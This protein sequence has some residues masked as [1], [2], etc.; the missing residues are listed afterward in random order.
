VFEAIAREILNGEL[1]PG[2]MLPS[3][4]ELAERF[5]ISMLVVRQAIHGLEDLGL[6]RVRQ[7]GP[8]MVLDPNKA[9]DIRLLELRVKLAPLG[10]GLGIYTLELRSLFMMQMLLLAE[11]RINEREIGV[12]TYLIDSLPKEPSLDETRHFRMEFWRQIATAT[13]NELVEQQMLWWRAR[14]R[15]APT[16]GFGLIPATPINVPFYR[17]L[18]RALEAHSGASTLYLTS[19]APLLDWVDAQRQKAADAERAAPS[20]VP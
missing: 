12:L 20:A 10:K 14:A 3:Q 18:V 7:G 1:E 6:V 9:T 17:A 13:R 11:R 16:H 19:I 8:T 4:R 2:V 15:E 5:S